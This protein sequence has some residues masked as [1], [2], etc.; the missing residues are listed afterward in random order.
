MTLWGSRRII[1]NMRHAA[2]PIQRPLLPDITAP[3]QTSNGRRLLDLYPTDTRVTAAFLRV[4]DVGGVVAEPCAGPG[5]MASVLEADG[6]ITSVITND[7]DAQHDADYHDDAADPTAVIW[8]RPIDWVITNPPFNAA[9][10]ILPVAFAVARVGV[11]FLLRLSYAEPA[12][13]RAQ[14]LKAHADHMTRQMILNPRPSFTGDGST[15]SVTAAWFVWRKG[16]S[17][18]RVGVAR[19][20][21]F[22]KDWKTEENFLN[23]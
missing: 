18:D 8:Q 9:H 13:N 4:E 23:R 20:F 10:R 5:W 2:Q 15:D 7:I 22:L 14:W 12:D 11:A 21:V 1:A 16:W 6:R 17:W 3:G 19:P